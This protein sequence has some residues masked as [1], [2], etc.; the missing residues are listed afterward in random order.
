MGRI[1]S[2][3]GHMYWRTRPEGTR[4]QICVFHVDQ[5]PVSIS[6]LV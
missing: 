4:A 6:Y 5:W 1:G 2:S 3:V